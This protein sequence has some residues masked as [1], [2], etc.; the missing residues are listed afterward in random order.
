MPWPAGTAA[1]DPA[2]SA[3]APV[4]S[5]C[6]STVQ[7]A[8]V[9]VQA[10]SC[11]IRID[12]GSVPASAT[13]RPH[14]SLHVGRLEVF[15]VCGTFFANKTGRSQMAKTE[16]IRARV[17]PEFEMPSRRGFRGARAIAHRGDHAVLSTGHPASRVTVRGKGAQCR[18][19]RRATAGSR[20]KGTHRIRRPGG[21]QSSARLIDAPTHHEAIREGS[22]AW[23]EARQESRHALECR[24]AAPV[25]TAS[26]STTSAASF[27]RG[28]VS[29][30]GMSH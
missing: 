11:G 20:R 29:L 21:S 10:R 7:S 13:V 26:R 2:R 28:L 1:P 5:T 8:P 3:P 6:P 14:R 17:E 9:S 15:P 23:Q 27:N 30:L 19:P 25:E 22:Q 18:D 12:T 16:M 24:G 4:D